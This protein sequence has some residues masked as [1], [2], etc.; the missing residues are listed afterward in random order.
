[1]PNA[2][3]V[4]DA[5]SDS[6]A[7]RRR[8]Q[9]WESQWNRIPTNG[10]SQVQVDDQKTAK[11]NQ[12]KLPKRRLIQGGKHSKQRVR[13]DEWDGQVGIDAEP[14]SRNRERCAQNEHKMARHI[15]QNGLTWL[16]HWPGTN[17]LLK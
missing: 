3:W 5:L 15:P 10:A 11:R 14:R 4:H 1:M 6:Q 8:E 2:A 13:R 7:A 16:S 9:H 12:G 17:D